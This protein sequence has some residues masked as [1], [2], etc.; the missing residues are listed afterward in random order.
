MNNVKKDKYE[1]VPYEKMEFVWVQHQYDVHIK[2]LCKFNNKLALFKLIK[3]SHYIT[4]TKNIF[5]K[6]YE[7][8]FLQKCYFLYNKKMFELCVGY[9]WTYP[10]GREFYYKKPIWFW[11]SVMKLYYLL[12]KLV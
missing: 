7:L 10:L 8:N 9:H 5:Y 1:I 4:D 6:V 11:G 3:N 12:N 2:G